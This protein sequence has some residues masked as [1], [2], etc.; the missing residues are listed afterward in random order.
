MKN[1]KTFLK[2]LVLS[3]ISLTAGFIAISLPFHIFDMSDST[4]NIVFVAELAIYIVIGL[5]FLIIKDKKEQEKIKMI[6]RHEKRN[7]KIKKVHEEWIN[8][9]A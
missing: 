8:L 1:F 6:K 2:G 7:E 3:L 9:A 5:I 4:M